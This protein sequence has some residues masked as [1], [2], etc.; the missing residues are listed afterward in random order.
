MIVLY[1]AIPC[2]PPPPGYKSSCTTQQSIAVGAVPPKQNHSPYSDCTPRWP[3]M[4]NPLISQRSAPCCRSPSDCLV[5]TRFLY[6]VQPSSPTTARPCVV[7][8]IVFPYDFPLFSSSYFNDIIIH[9][10]LQCTSLGTS[11]SQLRDDEMLMMII[12][13]ATHSFLS[14]CMCALIMKIL[15]KITTAHLVWNFLHNLFISNN[16]SFTGCRIPICNYLCLSYS[17]DT[18]TI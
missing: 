7:P 1:Y 6:I 12:I 9:S 18:H 11:S 8:Q 15:H 2:H 4:R 10:I 3:E 16:N 5:H 17:G 14:H 13:T